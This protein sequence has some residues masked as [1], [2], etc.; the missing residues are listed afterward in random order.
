MP[1]YSVCSRRRRVLHDLADHYAAAVVDAN[2]NAALMQGLEKHLSD[3]ETVVAILGAIHRLTFHEAA[4]RDFRRR[5]AVALAADLAREAQT[6][7][8]QS[9]AKR[10]LRRLVDGP[11]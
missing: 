2:G 6:A 1:L 5:G 4:R 10:V 9:S 8:V 7:E 3:A 11:V